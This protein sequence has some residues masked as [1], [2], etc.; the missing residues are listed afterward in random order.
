[1]RNN[2]A[3]EIANRL[4]YFFGGGVGYH[5]ID[6]ALSY[7]ENIVA[8]QQQ[9]I[10]DQ[11]Q[12]QGLDKAGQFFDYA[13]EQFSLI[14]EAVQ[15]KNQLTPKT[16]Q[17]LVKA[18]ENIKQHTASVESKLSNLGIPNWENT[19]AYQAL[20]KINKDLNDLIIALSNE[21]NTNHLVSNFPRLFEYLDS[22]TLLQESSLLHIILFMILFLTVTNILAVLFGNEILN[23][24]KLEERYPKLAVFF[25]LRSQL[26]R[27]YL[28]WNVSMLFI[29]CIFGIGVDLLLFTVK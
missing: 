27:Y 5:V 8:E 23:Y 29:V 4:A 10:R 13:R 15:A 28:I 20:I 14:H 26:Q 19:E 21:D 16:V 17:D 6:R 18:A 24:F 11:K 22:L 3:L 9:A 1:M 2:K 7:P 25:R 12:D